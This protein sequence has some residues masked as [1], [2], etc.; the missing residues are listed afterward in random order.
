MKTIVLAAATLVALSA[1]AFAQT[2]TLD[3]ASPMT[4]ATFNLNDP[5]LL[6]QQ[7]VRVGMG[8]Q[9]EGFELMIGG[10]AGAQFNVRVR[11]GRGWNT[12]AIV[13]QNLFTKPNSGNEPMFINV[14][15]AGIDLNADDTFVIETQGNNIGARLI[16]SYE[17]GN[18]LYHE[19]L[20]RNAQGCL[21]DCGWRHGFNTYVLP[22]PYD[23]TAT[24]GGNC[25]S[26]NTLSWTGAPA[27]STVR[28]LYTRNDG[29]SGT[30]WNT[31]PGKR[32]CV[33]LAGVIIHEGAYRSDGNGAGS[34]PSF[35]ALCGLH[36]QLITQSSCK[37]SNRIDL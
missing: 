5:S 3:Q 22:C 18:P 30:F 13:F 36:L 2:G 11:I 7:Q 25:P 21:A 33:G 16:G 12:G 34:I 24:L 8:G 20:Y 15:S 28:V 14:T 37:T 23:F 4:N 10:P 9:L 19:S 6:W 27:N 35:T 17:S 26:S 31:C 32:L 1:A 29:W